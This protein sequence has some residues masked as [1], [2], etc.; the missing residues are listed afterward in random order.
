MLNYLASDLTIA[1]YNMTQISQLSDE[2][3]KKFDKVWGQIYEELRFFGC[4]KT[5]QELQN[6]S[7]TL[8]YL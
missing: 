4:E 5:I 2:Q 8:Y 7:F 6:V 3:K 1:R